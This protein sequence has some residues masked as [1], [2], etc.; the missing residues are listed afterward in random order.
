MFARF[1]LHGELPP[2]ILWCHDYSR[3]KKT[4]ELV[5][6]GP[7][8]KEGYSWWEE[9]GVFY[10][11]PRVDSS[12]FRG[13]FY[14]SACPETGTRECGCGCFMSKSGSGGPVDPRGPCPENPHRA[15]I[16]RNKTVLGH[17]TGPDRPKGKKGYAVWIESG[18]WYTA[19]EVE[20][21][22]FG[23]HTYADGGYELGIRLCACGCVVAPS[24][25]AGPV[26][27][28]GPCPENPKD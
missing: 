19:P 1:L 28:F 18:V 6:N 17:A 25:S 27:P 9:N 23:G 2:G 10:T 22:K 26:D 5:P 20:R 7:A 24:S 11:A 12:K 8:L 3:V 16:K 14:H 13:H 21:D 15:E 4:I